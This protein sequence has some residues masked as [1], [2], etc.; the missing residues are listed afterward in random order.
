MSVYETQEFEEVFEA[1]GHTYMMMEVTEGT[2]RKEWKKKWQKA[3][4]RMRELE[5]NG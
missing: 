1:V 3:N 2:E 5:T 4:A